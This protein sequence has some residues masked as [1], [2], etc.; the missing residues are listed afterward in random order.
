MTMTLR[1]MF[2]IVIINIVL[3]TQTG[4]WNN[5]D[6]TRLAVVTAIGL[7]LNGDDIE[8][9][10][11]IIRPKGVSTGKSQGQG[12]EGEKN[13]IVLTN[14][15]KTVVEALRGLLNSIDRQIFYSNVQVII[16]GENLAKK[17]INKILDVFQRQ[18]QTRPKVKMLI[19]KGTPI[20]DILE[21]KSQFEEFSAVS[22]N[23]ITE[24]DNIRSTIVETTLIELLQNMKSKGKEV[25]IGTI[26]KKPDKGITVEGCAVF[27]EDRLV[28]WL[29]KDLT[30]G[31]RFAKGDIKNAALKIGSY[32]KGE[33][34]VQL[35]VVEV[36]SNTKIVW[37]NQRPKFVINIDQTANIAEMT[38]SMDL[39]QKGAVEGLEQDYSNSTKEK[40][41]DLISYMR[42]RK[43][44]VLGLGNILYKFHYSYWKRVDA[45][46]DRELSKIPIEVNIKSRIK[47]SGLIN[48]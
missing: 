40:I 35:E 37:E 27:E 1:K 15:E 12:A 11:Q 45:N 25:V 47:R 30:K 22:M 2:L 3:L 8:V 44:D 31:Y 33:N 29:D 46:W 21:T 32:Y 14:K 17:G 23:N 38:T 7:D 43:I 9:S 6:L 18:T 26:F 34:E 36:R 28:G 39:M 41:K 16:I 48:Q 4:C 13:Y 10:V 24:N 5:T 19:A 20:I 42:E